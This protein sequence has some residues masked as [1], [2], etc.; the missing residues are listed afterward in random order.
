MD[1][2]LTESL[3][4]N[5]L[6]LDIHD[7]MQINYIYQYFIYGGFNTIVINQVV[8]ILNSYILIFIINFLTNCVDYNGILNDDDNNNK[9]IS[10]YININNWFP[11]NIYLLI[12]FILYCIYLFCITLNTVNI[13]KTTKKVKKFYNID[14]IIDDSSLKYYTWEQIHSKILKLKE[15]HISMNKNSI[16]RIS[17][18]V[19][20]DNNLITSIFRSELF[21]FPNFSKLLEWNFI[22]C[23]IDPIQNS[24]KQATYEYQTSEFN[25]SMINE[26]RITSINESL[27][28]SSLRSSINFGNTNLSKTIN[29]K[30]N[31]NYQNLYSIYLKK[32]NSRLKLVFF[33]N[34]ISMPFAIIILGIYLIL[35]YGEKFYHNPKLIYQRQLNIKSKW[36]LT[37]YNEYPHLFNER[38]KQL[39]YNMNIIIDQYQST[40]F[41]IIYRL[42]V[43]ICGSIFI[44]LFSLTLVS[45][46]DFA[47]IILF[48]NKSILWFL[49]VLGT[50]LIIARSN[51]EEKYINRKE[52]NEIFEKLR[53]EL[54]TL[55]PNLLKNKNEQETIIKLINEIYPYKV[56][57][58]LYEIVYL[59]LSPYYLLKWKKQL[60]NNYQ[61]II[62][63]L[64]ND[65]DLGA[66]AKAS[67][68]DNSGEI[69]K[70]LHMYISYINFKKHHNFK[71]NDESFN[72]KLIHSFSETYNYSI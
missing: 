46:N 32:V 29:N 36:K 26:T 53:H 72:E 10:D 68:F 56:K 63:L 17:N 62:E 9:K 47:N 16:Y 28:E 65:L 49:S 54:I 58:I 34:I 24:V 3:I 64:D 13:I 15:D 19:C 7:N 55:D 31:V 60:M 40:I 6:T 48:D 66:V 23:I 35:K 2:L 61:K 4:S 33:I 57:F 71:F 5:D 1:P 12:C 70:D 52:K 25:N 18:K 44:V 30:L 43:F 45:G 50:F 20:H 37:L 69:E 59:L 22:Y 14:L 51:K 21:T 41:Q 8:K 11:N 27:M 67:V 39:Q 42:F 38:I